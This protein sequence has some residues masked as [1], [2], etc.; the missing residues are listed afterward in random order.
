MIFYPFRQQK[1]LTLA[2]EIGVVMVAL[3]LR[4]HR[5]SNYNAVG[6]WVRILQQGDASI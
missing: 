2:N 3:S 6:V 1:I 5:Q 4:R